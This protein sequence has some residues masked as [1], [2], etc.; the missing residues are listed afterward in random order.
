MEVRVEH[1]PIG[2]VH[3]YENNPRR[4]EAAVGP[5]MESIKTFGFKVPIVIDVNNIV[6]A[7]HTRL[8]AAKRLGMEEVPV[9]RATDLT[10]DQVKAYRLADNQ[11]AMLAE[12]D[13]D[14]LKYEL[15]DLDKV[16]D[17]Q[18]FGFED[19][20]KRNADKKTE[21]APAASVTEYVKCPRCGKPIK[22][23]GKGESHE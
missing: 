20:K 5:V 3:P 2:S 9:I 4:I 23:W 18:I 13:H 10:E 16:F 17:M 1:L 6:V 8:E 14:A 19:H 22:R 7:G 15:D 12:W 21:K 11:T